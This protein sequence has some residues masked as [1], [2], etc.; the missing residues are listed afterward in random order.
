MYSRRLS[1]CGTARNFCS[2]SRSVLA[3]SA[4]YPRSGRG[5][6][7]AFRQRAATQRTE[8]PFRMKGLYLPTLPLME[9]SA[10]KNI[11]L[12]REL[13]LRDM[14][15]VQCRGGGRGARL[16]RRGAG[17]SERD[18]PYSPSCVALFF[19]PMSILVAGLGRRYPGGRFLHLDSRGVRG[20]DRHSSAHGCIRSPF[21]PTSRP[22]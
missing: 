12:C 19:V 4:E 6:S 3:A 21:W 10:P 16:L 14:V 1:G 9:K 15:P 22:C 17:R 2:H 20:A 11:Q 18:S 7:A 5:A 8:T 13:G